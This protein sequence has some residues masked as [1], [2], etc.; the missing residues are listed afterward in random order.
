MSKYQYVHSIYVEADNG[1]T[2]AIV[3]NVQD[4]ETGISKLMII[5]DPMVPFWITKPTCQTYEHK[6][7]YEPIENLDMYTCVAH[8]KF[9]K[10][11]SILG[12]RG[13]VRPNV[14]LSNPYVY[15]A[16]IEPDVLLRIKLKKSNSEPLKKLNIGGL[17]IE[18]SVLGGEEICCMSFVD[19]TTHTVYC[20]IYEPFMHNNVKKIDNVESRVYEDISEIDK[21]VQREQLI[22]YDNLNDVTKRIVDKNPFKF[23][24]FKSDSELEVIKWIFD[25]IH[26]CKP[27]FVSIWNMGFDIPYILKR[28]EFRQ[29]DPKQIFCSNE[30]PDV[31][32]RVQFIPDR[33]KVEHITDRWDWLDITD[34]TQY[35]DSMCLYGRIRKV[36]GRDISYRLDYIAS[37]DLGAGKLQFGQNAGHYE[38][39]TTRFSEYVAYNLIDSMLLVLLD[40]LN[41]D[42]TSM[43]QLTG[44]SRLKD[45]SKQTVQLKNTFYDHCRNNGMVPASVGG[46]LSVDTDKYIVNIGGGVLSPD[47]ARG[48]GAPILIE[49]PDLETGMCVSVRDID[50]SSFYPNTA[51]M[52]N[53]AKETKLVNVLGIEGHDPGAAKRAELRELYGDYE[54]VSDPTLA[55]KIKDELYNATTQ[56]CL[57]N[58]NYFVSVVAP[59]ENSVYLL[60]KYHNLPNYKEMAELFATYLTN[61]RNS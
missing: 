53:I 57:T 31:F 59:M 35:V 23:K 7:E 11:A 8:E 45:F 46:S 55:K 49:A 9:R 17:D 33:S 13:Y 27:A 44:C 29:A 1:T 58:E 60:H 38:M 39:Q 2:S 15:G 14:I 19:G 48:V 36:Q 10:I 30:V 12:M 47:L 50:V 41:N 5:K 61:E 28:L 34:Y 3:A 20:S 54:N 4:T 52:S 26:K 16:D 6:K 24:Y 21:I 42:I 18:T 37:K 32:K 22:F 43:L 40:E 25:N 51:K 56:T